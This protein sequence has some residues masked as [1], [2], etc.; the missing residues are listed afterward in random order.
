ME[1]KSKERE[2]AKQERGRLL[3]MLTSACNLEKPL[4]PFCAVESVAVN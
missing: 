4:C 1:G 2:R 3:Y